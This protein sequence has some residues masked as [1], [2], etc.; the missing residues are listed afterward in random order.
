MKIV[1]AI[2]LFTVVIGVCGILLG[3]T[4]YGGSAPASP[5]LQPSE[6]DIEDLLS[7]PRLYDGKVV[8]VRGYLV[9]DTSSFLGEPYVLCT[10]DPREHPIAEN[11][12]V[13]VHGRSEMLDRYVSFLYDGSRF[14]PRFGCAPPPGPCI[15]PRVVVVEGVFHATLAAPDSWTY[16]IDLFGARQG[17]RVTMLAGRSIHILYS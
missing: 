17:W 5:I 13:A 8:V 7:N 3:T 4:T 6:V 10:G 12:C 14:Q 15:G 2:V 16:W 11:P 1:A 9:K